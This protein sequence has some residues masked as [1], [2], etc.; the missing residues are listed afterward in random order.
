MSNHPTWTPTSKVFN[1]PRVVRNVSRDG[2]RGKIGGAHGAER[3]S[4]RTGRKE[5]LKQGEGGKCSGK[6][7]TGWAVKG[8]PVRQANFSSSYVTK[9][10][11]PSYHHFFILI[12]HRALRLIGDFVAIEKNHSSLAA[13]SAKMN[14]FVCR[15]KRAIF[16]KGL[17]RFL[18]AGPSHLSLLCNFLKVCRELIST[19]LKTHLLFPNSKCYDISFEKDSLKIKM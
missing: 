3:R 14:I 19:K 12:R 17:P 13:F 9:S 8:F 10:S 4:A 7:G 2:E 5:S 6:R 1:T 18:A 11:L 15:R 16:S